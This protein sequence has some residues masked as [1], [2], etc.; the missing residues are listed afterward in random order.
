MEDDKYYVYGHKKLDTGELFYIGKGKKNRI[1]STRNRSKGWTETVAT[2]G[3]ISYIIKENLTNK[4]AVALEKELVIQNRDSLLNVVIPF[5]RITLDYSTMSDLF[6][7]DSTSPSCLRWRR[8]RE[9]ALG[10]MRKYKDKPAGSKGG[11]YWVVETSNSSLSVHRIIYLLHNPSFNSES[12]VDH[13]DG[14]S[15]NNNINNLRE[16]SKSINNK[17]R[18]INNP[19]GHS[20]IH[21]H[22]SPNP[23]NSYYY[24]KFSIK[25]KRVEFRFSVK[26][27]GSKENALFD[28]VEYKESIKDIMILSGISE[29]VL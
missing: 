19:N 17:N 24:L 1:N 4:E 8:D 20:F 29:R 11:R 28:C 10:R 25:S 6:Y 15:F 18:L 26:N 13:I 12:D 16:C 14:D 27:S 21:F 23:V 2:H 7:Y 3:F 5:E 22:E 9:D